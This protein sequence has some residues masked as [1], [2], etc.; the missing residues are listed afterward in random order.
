[1]SRENV[2]IPRVSYDNLR[3]LF[4]SVVL[5]RSGICSI[6]ESSENSDRVKDRD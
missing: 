4:V 1:M 3:N 5:S 2:I 6:C